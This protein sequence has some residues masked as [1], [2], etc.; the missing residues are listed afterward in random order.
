MWTSEPPAARRRP[1]GHAA[2]LAALG[3]AAS[4]GYGAGPAEGRPETVV[5]ALA[6]SDHSAYRK[7]V[8]GALSALTAAFPS[9]HVVPMTLQIEDEAGSLRMIVSARPSLVLAVGSRAARVVHSGAPGIPM[10]YAMVLD[11]GSVG[12]PGPGDAPSAGV[13]G[14]SLDVPLEDQFALIRSMVPSARRVGVLY[15]PSIS[16]DAVRKVDAAARSIGLKLVAQ[17]VR[18]SASALDAAEL[19]A[20]S[21]DVMI[22]IADPTVF[23]SANTRALI[24]L[25]LRA[26]VP[27][28]A[29]SEGFVRSG[30]LAALVPDAE[31]AGQRAGRIA[32]QILQG[33][34]PSALRPEPPPLISLFLNRASASHLGIEIT[35]EVLARA[36]AIFAEN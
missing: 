34:S 18:S 23:T 3:I 4:A 35:P 11:P 17:A 25:W 30:A 32:V 22:A 1:G 5:V 6:A 19:L 26:R 7:A 21:V 8:E 9:A 14:I 31:A 12:L 2:L 20:P 15:D 10:V 36:K 13:T 28:F 27:L 33:S 24:L 16:G 29:M